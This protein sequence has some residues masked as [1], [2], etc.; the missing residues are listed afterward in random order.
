LTPARIS[1]GPSTPSKRSDS[2]WALGD[3]RHLARE[4]E[5]REQIQSKGSLAVQLGALES[6]IAVGPDAEVSA[7]LDLVEPVAEGAEC[8][9]AERV[10]AEPRRC[11][12]PSGSSGASRGKVEVRAGIEPDPL[13]VD[14][15]IGRSGTLVRAGRVGRA[16]P[17]AAADLEG[18]L[19]VKRDDAARTRNT[20]TGIRCCHPGI[21]PVPPTI[22]RARGACWAKPRKSRSEYSPEVVAVGG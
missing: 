13:P 7:D 14:V 22:A 17:D 5:Q 2:I 11:R 12:R 20:S 1:V 19:A 18:F 6:A 21:R 16:E 15:Q 4:R 3:E 10:E 9:A 8:L